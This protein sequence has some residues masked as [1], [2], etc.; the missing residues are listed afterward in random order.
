MWSVSRIRSLLGY[1]GCV[2]IGLLRSRGVSLRGPTS[3][4]SIRRTRARDSGR[5]ASHCRAWG[6]RLTGADPAPGFSGT[7]ALPCNDRKKEKNVGDSKVH[8]L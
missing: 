3:G 1:R 7:E 2:A 5:W 6:F 8:S 4:G